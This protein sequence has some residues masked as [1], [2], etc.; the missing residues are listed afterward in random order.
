M[1]T[2]S[3]HLNG[4][5]G[6]ELLR[7]YTAAHEAV[8]HAFRLAQSAAPHGRDYYVQGDDA[9]GQALHEHLDRMSRLEDIMIELEG[10]VCSIQEQ[11]D[12]RKR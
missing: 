8:T 7:Q 5:S 1:K 12:K 10:I 4:T 9:I 6:S 3:I 11:L 2:P